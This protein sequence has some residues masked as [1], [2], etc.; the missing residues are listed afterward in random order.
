MPLTQTSLPQVDLGGVG[1]AAEGFTGA[2]LS[3]L[4]SEAQLAA[5]HEALDDSRAEHVQV[6]SFMGLH[7]AVTCVNCVICSWQ[8]WQQRHLA[9]LSLE[10]RHMRSMANTSAAVLQRSSPACT[11]ASF[12]GSMLSASVI[13]GS[14]H[15]RPQGQLEVCMMQ[16]SKYL[17]IGF[18]AKLSRMNHSSRGQPFAMKG[19]RVS[20]SVWKRSYAAGLLSSVL[21]RN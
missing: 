4:L 18:Y 1:R 8:A 7:A 17:P 13:D 14:K 3:S 11:S 21:L 15:L 2:D 12:E 10:A 6:C 19:M 16:T 9:R 5:V 20:A